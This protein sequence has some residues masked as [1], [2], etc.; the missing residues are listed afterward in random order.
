[1]HL[2]YVLLYY[3]A[4]KP[5]LIPIYGYEVDFNGE[6][7]R[8]S[9]GTVYKA[10][11]DGKVFAAKKI[12]SS[13]IGGKT[14]RKEID[15]FRKLKP[16]ENIVKV[17]D[18]VDDSGDLWVFSEYCKYGDLIKYA[19]KDEFK[20]IRTKLEIMHQISTGIKS[21]HEQKII[22]RDIKPANVLLTEVSGK[23]TVKLTDFGI[24]RILDPCAATSS[25][26]TDVGSAYFLAPEF[27]KSSVKYKKSIDIFSAGLTF[28]GIIQ[29]PGAGRN[30]Q[31]Y[32]KI[33]GNLFP[34]EIGNLKKIGEIMQLRCSSNK[35]PVEIVVRE[36][37]NQLLNMMKRIV[38]HC[39]EFTPSRRPTALQLNR[40]L[41]Q[42]VENP[43][44]D[45]QIPALHNDDLEPFVME[46]LNEV[47][48]WIVVTH[49]NLF[50]FFS[51]INPI[52]PLPHNS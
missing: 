22:H 5:A 10:T 47:R 45:L 25:M 24:A 44:L 40:Y 39:T 43:L 30:P 4:K 46:T 20:H 50:Q 52:D 48:T 9:H 19:R 3:R 36:P 13:S 51:I 1:M 35:E 15:I 49:E 31:M 2:I 27:F 26:S 28:L 34:N 7:G 32:P 21:L 12:S 17:F 11:K 29:A 23:L 14:I 38:K 6:I 18:V 16:H 42:L 41:G 37:N 33:E 8:G